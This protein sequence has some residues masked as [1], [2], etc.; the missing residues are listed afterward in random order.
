P[1]KTKE[2]ENINAVQVAGCTIN[3]VPSWGKIAHEIGH[4]LGLGHEHSRSD[5]GYYITI[6]W[7]NIQDPVQFCRVMWDQHTLANTPYDYDSIMHY[8]VDQSTKQSSDCQKLVYEGQQRCLAFVPNQMELRK[9]KQEQGTIQ[10]GQRDHL[11]KGDIDAVNT[12]Y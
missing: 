4:V 3:G 11:S 12:L 6:L 2:D 9:Q 10:I 8:S 7:D 5:G 1:G